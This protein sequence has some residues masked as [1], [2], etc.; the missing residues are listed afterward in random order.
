M[1]KYGYI[2]II[3]L[4]LNSLNYSH[5]SIYMEKPPVD[6]VVGVD[7]GLAVGSG[8]KSHDNF[9]PAYL[10]PVQYYL[11][12]SLMGVMDTSTDHFARFWFQIPVFYTPG[13]HTMSFFF[14]WEDE[15]GDRLDSE[16]SCIFNIIAN[17]S[18]GSVP[19]PDPPV[20]NSTNGS[21]PVPPVNN[22]TNGSD[23]VDNSTNGSSPV[24][25]STNG[26]DGSVVNP[27]E[28]VNPNNT[29]NILIDE[30]K[31]VE[32][33]NLASTGYPLAFA[34]G[35]LLFIVFLIVKRRKY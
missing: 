26:S 16:C 19:I 9:G 31:K 25:N 2:L 24:D 4:L 20:N 21:V 32:L 28:P 29:N 11:D 34:S 27:L 30:L 33:D 17:D 5:A 35:L 3:F 7:Q 14:D 13:T 22:S 1:F 18:N 12:G 23:P 10:G 6:S 15:D 8:L